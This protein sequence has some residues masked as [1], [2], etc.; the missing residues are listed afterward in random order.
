MGRC[1]CASDVTM[2]RCCADALA[3]RGLLCFFVALRHG[4]VL[5]PCST[6]SRLPWPSPAVRRMQFEMVLRELWPPIARRCEVD[7]TFVVPDRPTRPLARA[8]F[9]PGSIRPTEPVRKSDPAL[10]RFPGSEISDPVSD[11]DRPSDRSG[12]TRP[13]DPPWVTRKTINVKSTSRRQER[14]SVDATGYTRPLAEPV[15]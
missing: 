12:T 6:R 10:R 5:W 7:L 1:L 15:P 3:A 13:T 9:R 14:S 8:R 2:H 4:G 11:P